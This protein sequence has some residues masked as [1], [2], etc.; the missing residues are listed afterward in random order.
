M[1]K[2]L[3]TIL[4]IGLAGCTTNTQFGVEKELGAEEV[5]EINI[6][7]EMVGVEFTDDN[8]DEDIIIKSD[9]KDYWNPFGNFVMFFSVENKTGAKQ[10]IETVFDLK[11][12]DILE[13]AEYDGYIEEE[14]E[15]EIPEPSATSTELGAGVKKVKTT[16]KWKS[17]SLKEATKYKKDKGLL[18]ATEYIRKDI[19]ETDA[20]KSF[21]DS[22]EI[23]EKK[24][25]KANIETVQSDKEEFFLEAFG[26]GD[27]YGHLDPWSYEQNFDALNDAGLNGQDSWTADSGVNVSS[28]Y[29][30]LGSTKGVTMGTDNGKDAVRSITAVTSGTMYYAM[31]TPSLGGAGDGA[32][33]RLR[34]G[35]SN[36][37]NISADYNG[38][39]HAYQYNDGGT[40]QNLF[41]LDSSKEYV[42][43]VTFDC[44]DDL[45]DLRYKE[46]G[47]TWSSAT[48][49]IS[50]QVACTNIDDIRL[51]N[52]G[53]TGNWQNATMDEISSTDPDTPTPTPSAEVE[54]QSEFWF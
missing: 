45:Y 22:F 53:G 41:N 12:G 44:S 35:G 37:V 39:T 7:G 20:T 50:C 43:E 47:G 4:I 24:F 30:L 27:S 18:G 52:D 1:K 49:D 33:L 54:R 10:D 25:Y 51:L 48:T 36:C 9:K 26:D 8:T 31:Q 3:L 11:E 14:I 15:V 16:T 40:W 5:T 21:T 34:G 46:S 6:D 28:S 17:K 2:L 32:S 38:G 19:K 13:V 29:G 42:I 23:G